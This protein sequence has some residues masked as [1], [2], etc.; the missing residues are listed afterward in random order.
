MQG[1]VMR[2]NSA[3]LA[4]AFACGFS[5]TAFARDA[6]DVISRV[7]GVIYS[8]VARAAEHKW[9]ALPKDELECTA[10]KLVDHG[11]RV[12]SLARRGI[13]PSDPRVSEIRAGCSIGKAPP[14][15]GQ[16]AEPAVV[17]SMPQPLQQQSLA[18]DKIEEAESVAVLKQQVERLQTD[19][20]VSSSRIAQLEGAKAAAEFTANQTVQAKLDAE[21]ISREMQQLRSADKAELETVIAQLRADKAAADSRN[22]RRASLAYAG[23]AGLG[24]ILAG[25]MLVNRRRTSK[26]RG[27]DPASRD[28]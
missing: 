24:S 4:V 20:A 10:Q 23:I 22:N 3:V 15:S 25:L 26:Q 17:Q 14:S 5:N 13:F 1:A 28:S 9:N 21:N 11:N 27:T 6:N 7:Q 12:Q 2:M 19:L 8:A 18:Q 16:A